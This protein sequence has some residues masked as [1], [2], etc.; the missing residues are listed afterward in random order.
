MKKRVYWKEGSVISIETRKGVFVLAQMLKSPYLMF[1]NLFGKDENWGN[2][3]LNDSDV[4]FING[5]T[6][7]FIQKS[8]VSV[9][10][11][12][13]PDL[14][15]E[16]PICWIQGKIGN[17]QVT[18]W[19]GMEYEKSFL[20][21]GAEPGGSLISRDIT[22]G[23]EQDCKVVIDNIPL[24][25]DDIIN[26]NELT[27]LAVYPSMNERLYLCYESGINVD[28]AKDLKFDRKLPLAYKVFV[29]I[30]STIDEAEQEKILD[31]Y[32]R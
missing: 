1:Y 18:V 23:G 11:G 2:I 31:T 19:E 12:I 6:S 29:D 26:H 17:R 5:V 16:L 8:N 13:S 20:V 32:F 27:G 3:N 24:D 30:L 4:L 10:K 14:Q 21:L 25:A 22:K 15:R 9:Q 7:Q 28:P